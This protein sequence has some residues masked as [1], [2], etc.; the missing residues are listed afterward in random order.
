MTG[1]G[2]TAEQVNDGSCDVS[3]LAASRPGLFDEAWQQERHHEVGRLPPEA[4]A[5]L[6]RD[7]LA[8]R[9][10]ELHDQI[11]ALLRLAGEKGVPTPAFEVAYASLCVVEFVTERERE[12]RSLSS[13]RNGSVVDAMPFRAMQIRA[14][15]M[16]RVS[17][18]A[19]ACLGLAFAAAT[20]AMPALRR[21]RAA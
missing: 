21:L 19:M 15:Q 5:S 13:V 20:V 6:S 9:P 18:R 8:G 10:S 3:A 12:Q 17:R 14:M 2:C 4:S 16:P 1:A 7:I 11:G